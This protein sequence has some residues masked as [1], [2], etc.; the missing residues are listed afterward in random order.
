VST[1]PDGASGSKAFLVYARA[2][3]REA[4]PWLSLAAQGVAPG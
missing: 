3:G 4:P 2:E 1:W